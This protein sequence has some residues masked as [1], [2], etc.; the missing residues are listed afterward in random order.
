MAVALFLASVGGVKLDEQALLAAVA[1]A[2][3]LGNVDEPGCVVVGRLRHQPG[4]HEH[5]HKALELASSSPVAAMMKKGSSGS[6]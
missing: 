2:F 1:V 3:V 6:A 4:R 5:I